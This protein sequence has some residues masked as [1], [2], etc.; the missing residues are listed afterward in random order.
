MTRSYGV[1][2]EVAGP[3]AIFTRPDTGAMPTSYP[4]P[5]WSASKG[6]FESIAF[7]S[8]GS[9]WICPTMIQVCRRIDS[10]GGVHYQ[11]YT[12]NY[13]GPLRKPDLFNKGTLSGGSSM[14]IFSTTLYDVCYRIHG[15]AVAPRNRAGINPAHHL[16]D[17]FQR[18]LK[19]G[20]AFRTPVLGWSEF[21]C[22]YWGPFREGL[23]EVD[24]SYSD[25]IPSMLFGMWSSPAGG[26]Y[27]PIFRQNVRIV[28]GTLDYT[29]Y[30]LPETWLNPGKKGAG[31]HA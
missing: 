26:E 4:L 20:Q 2:I 30:N 6:I 10:S 29:Q 11:R 23:T 28:E 5:H 8:D 24:T 7:F 25:V 15:V 17:L 13:G 14:Q 31:A 3:I 1:E 18:R 22:S 19:R 21:T 16:Q 27:E 12:T 9:A